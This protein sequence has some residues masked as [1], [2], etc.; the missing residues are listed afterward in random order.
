MGFRLIVGGALGVSTPNKEGR[1]TAIMDTAPESANRLLSYQGDCTQVSTWKK[2]PDGLFNQI[3]FENVD[4][5]IYDTPFFRGTHGVEIVKN[6]LKAGG[7]VEFV[8]W[9]SEASNLTH[10]CTVLEEVGNELGAVVD[11]RLKVRYILRRRA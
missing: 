5:D 9:A 3:I 6:K 4:P 7:T 11:G 2:V 8:T 1:T 10:W